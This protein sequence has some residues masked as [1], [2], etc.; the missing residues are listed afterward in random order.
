V[1]PYQKHNNSPH[2][3]V[4]RPGVY[5][6]NPEYMV[7]EYIAVAGGITHQ[8]QDMESVRLI[9]PSGHRTSYSSLMPVASGDTIVVPERGFTRA[10]TAQLILSC[11]CLVISSVLFVYSV[12]R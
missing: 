6:Y 11:V 2:G 1:I 8:G 12:T 4:A 9:R 7:S 5:P 3:A 10:E